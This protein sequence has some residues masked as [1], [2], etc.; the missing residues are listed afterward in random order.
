MNNNHQVNPLIIA[1]LANTLDLLTSYIDFSVFKMVE[2]NNYATTM[3]LNSYVAAT[4]AFITY[5]ATIALIYLITLRYPITNPALA[6]FITMKFIAVA[7]NITAT[8]GFY[9][10]NNAL[11]TMSRAVSTL[12]T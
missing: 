4:L 3:H 1:T 12:N 5:E 8:M 2:L 7:G 9:Q 10:I 6:V 11:I